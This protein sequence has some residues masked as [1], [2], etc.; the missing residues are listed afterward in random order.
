MTGQGLELPPAGELIRFETKANGA[1]VGSYFNGLFY[2]AT[3]NDCWSPQYVT[4][5][6]RVMAVP[7]GGPP[8]TLP[9]LAVVGHRLP[10]VLLSHTVWGPFADERAADGFALARKNDGWTVDVV[11]VGDMATPEPGR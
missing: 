5:W 10:N 9:Q 6:C 2:S 8:W 7:A 11:P 3:S 4:E 1:V